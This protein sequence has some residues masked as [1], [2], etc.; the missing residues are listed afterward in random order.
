MSNCSPRYGIFS[1]SA[2][3]QRVR[4][5]WYTQAMETLIWLIQEYGYAIVFVWTFLEGETIVALAG[6]AAYQGYLRLEYI[7]PVA[8][9]GAMLGDQAFFYFGR[10]KGKQFLAK[11]PKW[12]AKVARIHLAIERYHG[13]II[14]GSRFMYGFRTVIPIALGVSN[15]SAGKFFVLNFLGAV[16]WGIFFAFGGYAFANAIEYF[17]GNIKK[18]EGFFLL[19]LL[20]IIVIAQIGMWFSRRRNRRMLES[21]FQ[22]VTLS[23]ERTD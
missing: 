21:L 12:E 18:I 22:K 6:F 9:A 8:V 5:A 1:R 16:V 23:A 13:W 2:N 17:L 15:V 7:I 14:F 19:G 11:R 4:R 10:L 3:E 20:T